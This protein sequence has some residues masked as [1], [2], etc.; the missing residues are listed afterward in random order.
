[1]KK[2]LTGILTGIVIL[3]SNSVPA[4]NVWTQHNDQAR[5]GWYPYETTLTTANVNKNSLGLAFKYT[6]DDK[7]VAQPLV[8][9]NVNL[10]AVGHKNVV[11]VATQNNSIY[12]LDADASAAPYWI[13]NY[14]TK[15]APY[16]AVCATCRPAQPDEMHP[17]LCGGGYGDFHENMGL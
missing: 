15:I 9:K 4:Q 7:I 14:S 10:P 8:V 5:T 17:S 11:F 2:F 16:G 13:A 1:M 3:F 12:A 6:V